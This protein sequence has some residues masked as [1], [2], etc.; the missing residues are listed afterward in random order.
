MSAPWKAEPSEYVRRL[1]VKM[2]NQ[3]DDAQGVAECLGVS[4]RSVWRWLSIWRSDG[5]LGLTTA[6]RTGRPPKLTEQVAAEVLDWVDHNPREFGFATE[7]W[8]TRRI[9]LLL[10]RRLGVRINRRYLSRW[11]RCRGVTPQT[12][13]HIPR[14]RDDSLVR[15]WIAHRWPAIKKKC[16]TSTPPLLLRTKAGSC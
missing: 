13:Q 6:L 7:R 10:D 11:L 1:A 8:T 9:A 4:E 15:G 3:G 16:A 14:E 12:P 2:V 5:D